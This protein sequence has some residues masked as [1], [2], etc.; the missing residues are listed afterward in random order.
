LESL[1]TVKHVSQV[2]GMKMSQQGQWQ[3]AA[4]L[5]TEGGRQAE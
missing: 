3:V 2:G 1:V 5:I 4:V